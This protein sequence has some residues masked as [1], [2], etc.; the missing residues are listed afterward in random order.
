MGGFYERLV[1]IVKRS[2]RNTLYRKLLADVQL[3]TTL[4]EIEVIVNT[5]PLVYVGDDVNSTTMLTP[6]N[7]L[8]INPDVGVPE[9]DYDL[10]DT[11]YKPQDCSAD[12]LIKV[13]KKGHKLLNTFWQ[14]WRDEYLLS[15]RERTQSKLKTGRIVS[16]FSPNVGNVVLIKDE[17]ARGLWKLEKLIELIPSGDK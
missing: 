14:I 5:C 15:L 17:I 13:W 10:N 6:S 2:L 3:H 12:K 11:E 8:T 16:S 9:I 1:A 7:F 4:K